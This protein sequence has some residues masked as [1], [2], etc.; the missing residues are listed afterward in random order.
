MT[1]KREDTASIQVR[2]DKEKAKH[3]TSQDVR[4]AIERG[5]EDGYELQ[6]Q[7][8]LVRKQFS[9]PLYQVKVIK[10]IARREGMTITQVIRS[11]L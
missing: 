1:E 8:V 7:P 11:F 2:I 10:K 9:L 3:L 6:K 5:L 4:E